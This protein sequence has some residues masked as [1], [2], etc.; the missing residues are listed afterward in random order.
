M[1]KH[2]LRTGGPFGPVRVGRGFSGSKSAPRHARN[3][4]GKTKNGTL[5]TR[6]VSRI[7]RTLSDKNRR[8]S[9]KLCD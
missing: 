5:V 8:S 6:N 4:P 1:A 3:H 2:A 7:W 9:A